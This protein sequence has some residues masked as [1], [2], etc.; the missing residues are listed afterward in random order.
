MTHQNPS[1]GNSFFLVCLL[2]LYLLIMSGSVQGR[3]GVSR[4]QAMVTVVSSPVVHLAAWT[5]SGIRG[6]F[7]GIRGTL[8]ARD[9]NVI[10]REQLEELTRENAVLR[11]YGE[12]NAGLRALLSMQDGFALESVG[13][14]VVAS[15]EN[16]E[17]RMIVINQGSKAGIKVDQ[18][19]L[20]W[21][22][23]VGRVVAVA[24]GY[25][26]VL[27]LTDPNSGVAAIVQHN[28]VD[29]MVLG[30]GK[31]R[32]RMDYVSRF[33]D[34]AIGDIIV[35]SGLDGIFPRGFQIGTVTYVGPGNEASQVIYLKPAVAMDE[36]EDVLVLTGPVGKGLLT[37]RELEIE[38]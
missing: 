20:A 9:E 26:K 18:A 36:M 16:D 25:S 17:A 6:M 5:G 30:L 32:L 10:F 29:G 19:V 27:G 23:A 12:Q 22:G 34:V 35:S 21:G 2:V 15:T 33:A 7:L 8:I 38:P 11:E 28:R 31:S 3:D 13:A 14:S 37:S 1:R 24:P 4:L